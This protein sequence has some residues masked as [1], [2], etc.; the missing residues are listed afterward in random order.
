VKQGMGERPHTTRQCASLRCI[1]TTLVSLSGVEGQSDTYRHPC[2]G[3]VVRG[4]HRVVLAPPSQNAPRRRTQ[5]QLLNDPVLLT[6]GPIPQQPE[7]TSPVREAGSLST[8]GGGGGIPGLRRSFSLSEGS[9][10][11]INVH[12][13]TLKDTGEK[14]YLVRLAHLYQ[15]GEDAYLSMPATVDLNTLLPLMEYREVSDGT[16]VLVGTVGMRCSSKFSRHYAP[17]ESSCHSDL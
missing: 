5:Q 16:P 3:L 10:L 8:R 13:L 4:V 9:I 1:V 11:P 14:T 15:A 12:L 17:V 6:F 7:L 2:A